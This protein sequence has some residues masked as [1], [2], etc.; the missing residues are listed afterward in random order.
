M[1]KMHALY[2]Y[3]VCGN[4]K[5]CGSNES[6]AFFGAWLRLRTFYFMPIFKSKTAIPPQCLLSFNSL[7]HRQH[8]L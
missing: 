5:L 7:C 6:Y 3:S 1:V 8:K 4:G 2:S